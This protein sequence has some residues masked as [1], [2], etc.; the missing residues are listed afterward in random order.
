MPGSPEADE[1]DPELISAL[2]EGDASVLEAAAAIAY[3]EAVDADEYRDRGVDWSGG[4]ASSGTGSKIKEGGGVIAG[5][6][7]RLERAGTQ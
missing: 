1:I 5:L 2:E 6:S 4:N 7:S 3:Q